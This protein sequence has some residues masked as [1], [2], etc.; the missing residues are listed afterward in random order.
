M[1]PDA[2]AI[3]GIGAHGA[4]GF[5]SNALFQTLQTAPDLFLERT[6]PTTRIRW[7]VAGYDGSA[8]D[9]LVGRIS[10]G[11]S[12]DQAR[13]ARRDGRKAPNNAASAMVA[14]VEAWQQAGLPWTDPAG[15]FAV[16]AAAQNTTG[17]ALARAIRSQDRA[18]EAPVDPWLAIAGLDSFVTGWAAR[19]FGLRGE[20]VTVGNAQ[21]SGH[22]AIVQAARMLRAGD[23]DAVLVLGVPPRLTAVEVE[24]CR[25]LSAFGTASRPFDARADG[26]V[27]GET[28]AALIL[29]RSDTAKRRGFPAIA[30]LAAA[31]LRLHG[32]LGP[33]PDQA[34]EEAIMRGALADAGLAP[35]DIDLVCAHATGT[36]A[37]DACEAGAIQSVF[38]AGVRVNAPKGLLGHAL[39]AAGVLETVACCLQ[40]REGFVHG[41]PW[42]CRPRDFGAP[43]L[44]IPHENAGP[45]SLRHVLNTGFGFGGTNAALVLSGG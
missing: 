27:P 33:D 25:S 43:V 35:R 13:S 28:A 41:N 12:I 37:G 9:D 36:P 18:P 32:T 42:I 45:V 5:D 31:R 10:S 6:D 4:A 44:A 1:A 21:A 23:A 38:G 24:S 16:V 34:A 19:L 30:R 39:S 15:R 20:A 14:A 40:M 7:P 2:L 11:I 26:F 8:L 3:T 22:G 17:G 29:E